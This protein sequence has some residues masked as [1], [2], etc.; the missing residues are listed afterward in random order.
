MPA[1]ARRSL[2][3]FGVA[4]AAALAC[5][6]TAT[7]GLPALPPP[8]L[9]ELCLALGLLGWLAPWRGRW[10]GAALAGFAW[11][12]LIAGHVIDQRVPAALAGPDITIVGRIDGLPE[13]REGVLRFAFVTDAAGNPAGIAG[14]K[15][16][17]GWYRTM[18]QVAPG[19]RWRFTVKLRRP[20]GVLDPGGFDF[21]RFALERR[22][23][24]TGY[25]RDDGSGDGRAAQRLGV[26]WS[27]DALRARW[28]QAI[29]RAV[30]QSSSRFLSALALGDTR[31]LAE[32]DW[33]TLRQTGLNHQVAISGFHVGV[34]A[35]FGALLGWCL[36]WCFPR[37]G[38]RWPRPLALPLFALVF[39]I[40]YAAITGFQLPTVRTVLM[41]AVA[42]SARIGRRPASAPDALALAL[43]AMLA[44]DPLSVLAP[45]FWLSFAGV[46][47]LL[48][49]L[50][51][52]RPRSHWRA[53]LAGQG[54]ATLGLLPL[55]VWFFSQASIVAPLANLIGIPGFA[56]LVTPLSILG[57]ALGWAWPA[58][59]DAVLR[60][61]GHLMDGLWWVVTHMASW[62]G[63][64]IWIPEPSLLALVLAS[65]GAFWLLLPRG[66][67]G[68]PLALLLWL[69]LLYPQ[70]QTIRP[71][72]ADLSMIDVGQ[73]LSLLV[74][75][76]HHTLVFDTGPAFDGGL[77]LGESAVVPTLHAL[78]VQTLDALVISHGDNDHAGGADAVRR[79]FPVALRYA[80]AGWPQ[81]RDYQPCLQDERWNWDG[82]EFRF[83]H[84][85]QFMPY[86]GNDSGCV[87]R[88]SGP[89]W[90]A[91]LPADIEA[92]IEQ[93][94]VREQPRALRADLLVVPHHGSATSSTS[95]FL[96][97]VAPKLALISVGL[98]NRFGHPK[99]A[100]VQRYL[101]AHVALEDSANAGLVRVRLAAGGPVVVE[102]TRERMRRFWQEPAAPAAVRVAQVPPAG[103][104]ALRD[105][106][107]Q[108]HA[109]RA[110]RD[111]RG[112]APGVGSDPAESASPAH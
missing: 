55:T 63:A 22:I 6:A 87:L 41:I 47:W 111:P 48:W 67:P 17:L 69:P 60:L 34:V 5:G 98:D 26:T 11:T 12:C 86:L 7:M 54:V 83:L 32:A 14:R 79:A 78:G 80:P 16:R 51:R 100:V 18:Q 28:S 109:K 95:A 1:S 105:T 65:I 21:E 35:S 24:A 61:A 68:K 44:I 50:P 75:T 36:W 110:R 19:E 94:L 37:L 89:G 13:Q 66:I 56:L 29:A 2:R 70:V 40:G 57:M 59:G 104:A 107:R 81:G 108:P 25:V 42:L 76:Q 64:L 90:A 49:C 96:T 93:R 38:L 71:G 58:G 45:G 15:I 20:R 84:P 102:R 43:I 27:I 97:A 112:H 39:G 31:G 30:P 4:C 72:T 103:P 92:V 9:R 73:G 23:A 8:W 88:V 91:L 62:P 85:P 101:D 77:D 52:D 106:S 46:A 10:I 3:G 99:P 74:R 33:D 53:L 82:V